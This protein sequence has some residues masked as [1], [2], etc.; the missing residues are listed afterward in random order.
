MSAGT[1]ADGMVTVFIE[2][3]EQVTYAGTVV[4]TA[5]EFARLELALDK[6]GADARKAAERIGD[7]LHRHDDWQ[8]AS[9]PDIEQFRIETPAEAAQEDGNG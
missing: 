5:A 9:D 1:E 3:T 2:F 4:V 6:G 8:G 7:L